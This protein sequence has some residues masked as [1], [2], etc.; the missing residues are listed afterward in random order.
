MHGGVQDPRWE[1]VKLHYSQWRE[2]CDGVTLEIPQ[3]LA[4]EV[5]LQKE[6]GLE[7]DMSYWLP[8]PLPDPED[9]VGRVTGTGA[10]MAGRPGP[11]LLWGPGGSREVPTSEA[12][13]ASLG[14][15]KCMR[16]LAGNTLTQK[17]CSIARLLMAGRGPLRGLAQNL[18][19]RPRPLMWLSSKDPH[20]SF[21]F[22]GNNV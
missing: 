18:L 1:V 3:S 7:S 20:S 19:S 10:R 16:K 5:C 11:R 9:R 13:E 15:E 22:L 14:S 4:R 17:S 2:V 6:P 8:L 21:K 12:A